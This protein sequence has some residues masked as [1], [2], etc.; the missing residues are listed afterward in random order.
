MKFENIDIYNLFPGNYDLHFFIL[1]M[2]LL[3]VQ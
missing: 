1:K 2:F 3:N